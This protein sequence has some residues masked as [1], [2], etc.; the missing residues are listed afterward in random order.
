MIAVA[1]CHVH[2]V[3]AARFPLPPGPGYRPRAEEH[4][5]AEC[6]A[7][8]LARYEVSHALV[9]QPS[10]YGFDNSALLDALERSSGRWRG[11]AMLHPETPERELARLGAAGVVGVRFNLT[12]FDRAQLDS[13]QI[14]K[15]LHRLRDLGWFAEIQC[16]CAVLEE[17]D[18]LSRRGGPTLLIDHLGLPDPAGGL[19]QPGFSRLCRL[20]R[21]GRAVLKLSGAYRASKSPP[22]HEELDPFAE[23][24]LEAF[25]PAACVW[26]SDWPF[27]G[28][29]GQ[30]RYEDAMNQ[31]ARWVPD[32]DDRRT[33]LW[34]TPSRLFGFGG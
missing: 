9:V 20:G 34:Q 21:E 17:L 15:F 18:V 13:P 24:L 29:A 30:I 5:P 8:S 23:A 10:G 22:P 32:Q 11:I 27:L 33:V 16:P 6:L 26:G 25:G 7:E 28:R 19:A 1:D 4:A 2:I 12:D 3:D 14:E 31:L